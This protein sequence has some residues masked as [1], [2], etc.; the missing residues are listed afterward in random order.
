MNWPF[1]LDIWITNV[2]FLKA[3]KISSGSLSQIMVTLEV[4][5]FLQLIVTSHQICYHFGKLFSLSLLYSSFRPHSYRQ[6]FLSSGTTKLITISIVSPIPWLQLTQFTQWVASLGDVTWMRYLKFGWGWFRFSCSD[7]DGASSYLPHHQ[8]T[9]TSE[10]WICRWGFRCRCCYGLGSAGGKDTFP[11]LAYIFFWDLLCCDKVVP[12]CCYIPGF[13]SRDCCYRTYRSDHVWPFRK[14]AIP[15]LSLRLFGL[16]KCKRTVLWFDFTRLKKVWI[17]WY[18]L[19]WSY[20]FIRNTCECLQILVVYFE[21]L[22]GRLL[23]TRNF[24]MKIMCAS[25]TSFKL[26]I[27]EK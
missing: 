17:L 21:T 18:S 23:I 20:A 14:L 12:C 4:H 7:E 13:Y 10:N 11:P 27:I 24:Y 26:R 16:L 9:E 25:F 6:T 8:P 2:V 1:N 15:N 19:T 22:I 3:F 5:A